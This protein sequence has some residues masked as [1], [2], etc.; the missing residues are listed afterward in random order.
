M[1]SLG[2]SPIGVHFASEATNKSRF[3][4]KRTEMYFEFVEWIK[5][6]GALPESNELLAALTQ[7]TYTFKG[8]RLILEPKD[9]VKAKLGYSP[10]EADA[11]ALTFAQPV[12]ARNYRPRY[13]QMVVEY[14]PFQEPEPTRYSRHSY[15]HDPFKSW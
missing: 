15:D 8:D 7:T 11:A 4:N 2:Q 13:R 1:R 3:F 5:R 10:D 6:G 12:M 9:D 14:D